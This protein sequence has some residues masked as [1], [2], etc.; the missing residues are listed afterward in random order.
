MSRHGHRR[1]AGGR[2][3]GLSLVELMIAMLLG[4]IVVAGVYNMY[5]GTRHSSRFTEG[6]Q[7]MQENGR[8]GVSVLQRGLRLAG[9]SPTV[10]LGALDMAAGSDSRIVVQLLQGHDCNGNETAADNIA[11]NTYA[12]DAVAN[13]IT[14]T[15]NAAKATAMPI[16]EGVEGFRVL[17]GLDEDGDDV[18]E[19]YVPHDAALDPGRIAALRFALLVNSG[20]P[21]RTRAV[22]ESYVLLDRVIEREDRVARTVF[23]STVKLRNRR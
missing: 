7:R 2:Q 11:V 18:P 14:C 10:P 20:E 16:V 9:Y 17:Y 13:T 1:R 22:S 4:L 21:I 12:H 8:F 5:V 15:G 6:L 19:R 3:R 23:S